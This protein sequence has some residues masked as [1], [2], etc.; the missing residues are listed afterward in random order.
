MVV[1]HAWSYSA[2][3][4]NRIV[5][6][7]SLCTLSPG[8]RPRDCPAL[9]CTCLVGYSNCCRASTRRM[10]AHQFIHSFIPPLVTVL[11]VPRF[12]ISGTMLRGGVLGLASCAHGLEFLW[13]PEQGLNVWAEVCVHRRPIWLSPI[14]PPTQDAI[15]SCHQQRPVVPPLCINRQQL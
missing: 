5:L 15:L 7:T 1:G 4:R 10:N 13:R 11:G 6:A 9:A 8:G 3:F 2:R 14:C 12:L